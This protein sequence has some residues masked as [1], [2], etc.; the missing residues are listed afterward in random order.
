MIAVEFSFAWTPHL[1]TRAS[2][3]DFSDFTLLF[4]VEDWLRR[5]QCSDVSI[6]P[7]DHSLCRDNRILGVTLPPDKEREVARLYSTGQY[8]Q[9]EL[10][11]MFG[12]DR[13]TIRHI[14][15]K[16]HVELTPEV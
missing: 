9:R 1:V 7:R 16:H 11:T 13:A 14:I 2:A 5:K 12:V 15:R 4:S 3:G 10:V 8:R 6:T